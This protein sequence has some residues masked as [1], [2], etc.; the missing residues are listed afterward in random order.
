[1][2]FLKI[3]FAL[4]IT[5]TLIAQQSTDAIIHAFVNDKVL[6]SG[7]IGI[8]FLALDS[9]TKLASHND[10]MSMTPAST[11]KTVTTATALQKLGAGYTFLNEIQYT[12]KIEEGKISGD[13]IFFSDGDPGFMS[14]YF[15]GESGYSRA[16][17]EQSI[18]K[19]LKNLR[20]EQ[21]NGDII[22]DA[23]YY[24]TDA[25]PR[26]W[27]YHDLGNYYAAGVWGVSIFDNMYK[28]YLG[29]TTKVGGLVDIVR[30]EPDFG[31][32]N[33]KSEVRTASPTSGDNAY[34][35]APPYSKEGI[36]RGTIPAG[37]SNF[38]IKGAI[39][40]VPEYL[41]NWLRAL[42][43]VS[44][45][46]VTGAVKVIY[47]SDNAK[48]YPIWEQ[49]SLPLQKYVEHT[50]KESVNLFA[51]AMAMKLGKMFGLIQLGTDGADV[52]RRHWE[53][54]GV[55]MSGFFQEDGSGLSG[56]NGITA[57]QMTQIIRK[58]S[59]DPVTGEIFTSSL[60]AGG[61][62]GTVKSMFPH[63]SLKGN[64]RLKSGFIGRV[65]AYTGVFEGK[66]GKVAFAII[67][68]D[69]TCSPSVMRKKIADFLDSMASKI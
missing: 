35:F 25:V 18:V 8:C 10:K 53:E 29:R 28:L 55:D 15:E 50:N 3:I 64:I 9:G 19:S 58:S 5:S 66:N 62:E 59:I 2:G 32:L 13:L 56:R 48:R 49:K 60:P 37:V 43:E 39:P 40:N 63:S 31:N 47:K 23:S 69:F 24:G 44:G 57:F 17:V 1:M 21:I 42:L 12:G 45:I 36:V 20:V 4:L 51:E 65:R 6:E 61:N 52:I 7:R 16:E 30:M 41:G 22:I 67:A 11:L 34:I 68:N 46:K 26:R 38:V 33:L 27:E 54:R 14:S